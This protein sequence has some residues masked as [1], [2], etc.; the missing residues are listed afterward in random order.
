MTRSTRLDPARL[1]LTALFALACVLPGLSAPASGQLRSGALQGRELRPAGD[2]VI[3]RATGRPAVGAMGM[4]I[5]RSPDALAA[6]GGGRFLVVVCSGFG[7]RFDAATNSGQQSLQVIDLGLEPPQVVQNVY[8]PAPQ[9]ASVGAVFD[10]RAA[11]DGSYPLY[12]SGGVENHVWVLTFDPAAAQPIR[13]VSPGPDTQVVAAS[14]SVEGFAR[15]APSPRYNNDRAPVYPLGVALSSDGETLY[16]ANNLADNLGIVRDLRGRRDLVTVDLRPTPTIDAQPYDVVTVVPRGGRELVFVSLWA[17]GEVVRIDPRRPQRRVERIP[18]ARH[19]TKM[20]A[21]ADGARLYV[22]CSNGDAVSVIDTRKGREVERIHT[23]LVERDTLLGASPEGLALAANGLRL[24]VAN[25]HASALAVVELSD[26]ARGVEPRAGEDE[27]SEAGD[28][29]S[30]DSQVIG[31][32]P[33][34]LYPSALAVANGRLVVAN[35]KGTGFESSSLVVTR[36]GLFP[37]APN[38]RFPVRNQRPSGQDIKSLV[39]GN[40]SVMREPEGPALLESTQEAMRANGL[41]GER[42]ESLFDGPSPIRHVIY[43]IKENRT[44]DQVFGDLE[45]AGDGTSADGDPE[46]AIFGQG[47]AARR[48]GGAPQR[49][50][51]NQRALA[52][53]FGL[54]D[55]FFVNAEASPDGHNW[56]TAA[57]SSDYVD[58]AFRWSYSGRGRTYDFEGFN[59]LPSTEPRRD[60]PP[61]LPTPVTVDDISRFLERYIPYRQGGR[62]I[63]EPESLYLWDAAQREGLTTRNYG[64]FV[65][66]ITEADL[67]A[68]NRN[69]A[70]TYPDLSPN[71]LALPT[72]RSLEHAHSP[73]FRNFD[74]ETPDVM[75]VASYQAARA[76]G[77]V[78]VAIID[79]GQGAAAARGVSRYSVWREELRGYIADLEAGR[80]DHLPNLSIVRLSSNH[81]SG[82][83]VGMPTPQFMVA[84][85]DL[86]VGLLVQEVSHSPYWRDTAIV[87]LEDDA[88]NGPDHVDGHRSPALVISAYNRRGALV[89]DF[90][91][92]VS[93][94]RTIELLL[95]IEPMNVLDAAAVPIDLFQTEPDL[96]PFEAVLPLVSDDNLMNPERRTADARTRYF[97]DRSAEQNLVHADMA[98]P[99]ELNRILWFSVRGAESPMPAPGRLPLYAA[100]RYGLAEE[101]E[102]RAEEA[103][104]VREMKLYLARHSGNPKD[105]G[106]R[107]GAPA[108]GV[109]RR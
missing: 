30:T 108:T 91:N 39:A 37:N 9:S 79:P 77:N 34:G 21:S 96:T 45:A 52:L 65:A 35:G 93:A 84:D 48:L 22:A 6:D 12:V 1:L 99:D 7:V 24:Y 67:E 100:M 18:V 88:Q 42:K 17:T 43:V 20:L 36:D 41:L 44:Y 64:E 46:L 49:I 74:M 63:A 69:L 68:F 104:P 75:T 92:T 14:I 57:F 81:T 15:Q 11:S 8:F 107:R 58:K 28:D 80:G 97:I 23:G 54:L 98:D 95:G 55:R 86:A 32:V 27:D 103:D 62:D 53:R 51:P 4:N 78:D 50:T 105:R 56:S 19:P 94:I 5:V 31:F 73:A 10:H 59:R 70:K 29:D 2:L 83:S 82:L 89:H 76:S 90:H 85:N 38:E 106:E 66:T 47:E 61:L 16:A 87:V 25:A 26:T 101:A 60:S 71:V 109:D 3:D 40:L 33:T 72:K 13:E 102:E